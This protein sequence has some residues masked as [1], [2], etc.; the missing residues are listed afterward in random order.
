MLVGRRTELAQPEVGLRSR[1]FRV[2]PKLGD[3]AA[4]AERPQVLGD[5]F[6]LDGE[7][8][9]A[10]QPREVRGNRSCDRDPQPVV[11]VA[12]YGGHAGREAVL[13]CKPVRGVGREPEVVGQEDDATQGRGVR[14]S[15][16]VQ[17]LVADEADVHG[18]G[19]CSTQHHDH[20]HRPHSGDAMLPAGRTHGLQS[21][22]PAVETGSRRITESTV[23]TLLRNNAPVTLLWRNRI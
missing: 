22:P 14:R 4:E 12:P 16:R 11:L 9:L 5:R 20:Q 21:C 19:E 7:A 18:H 13:G 8:L 15:L 23:I 1:R 6:A 2:I 3:R 17:A 10:E